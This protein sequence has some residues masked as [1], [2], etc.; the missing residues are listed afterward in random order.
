MTK[1]ILTACLLSSLVFNTLK[2]QDTSPTF[3]V[4]FENFDSS[5]LSSSEKDLLDLL[6]KQ[7]VSNLKKEIEQ[8]QA[9]YK[10]GRISKTD[11]EFQKAKRSK[12]VALKMSK[13]VNL[14][15]ESKDFTENKAEVKEEHS[16]I[17]RRGITLWEALRHRNDSTVIGFEVNTNS[18]SNQ[19]YHRKN[20]QNVY[21]GF[22]FANWMDEDFNRYNNPTSSLD[23][24]KSLY[25]QFSLI[26]A[27]YFNPKTRNT[28]IDYG[29]TIMS[30]YQRFYNPNYSINSDHNGIS[31]ISNSNI[32][33]SSLI[34]TSIELPLDF[35]YR[36]GKIGKRHV[37]LSVGLYAG[38][39]IRSKQK[40][41]YNVNNEEYRSKIIGDFNIQRFYAG[42]K[43]K[44]GYK[45]LLL[46]GGYNFTEQFNNSNALNVNPYTIGL[47]FKM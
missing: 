16:R 21:F 20:S 8:L 6:I 24:N 11:F 32:T 27:H 30:K 7:E 38:L 46:E 14:I 31:T 10:F 25:F 40:I 9:D 4:E 18:D 42:G 43:F 44:I 23:K 35:T 28:S 1:S 3:Q 12:D 36:L 22:G 5:N 2:A 33:E 34:Q 17:N 45:Y 47:A 13:Y 29:I 41:K 26:N 39:K 15:S 37:S 19:V